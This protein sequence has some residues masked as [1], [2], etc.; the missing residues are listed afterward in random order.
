MVPSR[1]CACCSDDPPYFDGYV[2]ENLLACRSAH[3]LSQGV[4][5]G[6]ARNGLRAAFVSEEERQGLLGRLDAYLA[7][8]AVGRSPE[9]TA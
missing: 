4:I 3:G 7:Q 5:V 1:K 2:A 6:L 8:Q 9:C